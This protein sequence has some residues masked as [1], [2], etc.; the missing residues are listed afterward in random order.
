[1]SKGLKV[2]LQKTNIMVN[3]GITVDGMSKGMVYQCRNCSL[4]VK[5]NSVLCIQCG[6]WIHDICAGVKRVTPKF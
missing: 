5:A 2:S 6:K 4:K 1:M 3:C